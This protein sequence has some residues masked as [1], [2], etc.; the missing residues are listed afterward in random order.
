[1]LQ[2]EKRQTM[3]LKYHLNDIPPF[4]EFML[5][6]LQWLAVSVPG[7]VT[8]GRVVG[9]LHFSDPLLRLAYLQKISFAVGVVLLAQILLGHRLPLV[10]G[11]S[12]VLLITIGASTAFDFNTIYFS[13]AMGGL[14]LFV[15]AATG[16][17]THVQR[18]FTTRVIAVVLLLIAFTLMPTVLTL[19][20]ATTPVSPL[21]GLSFGLLLVMTMFVAQRFLTALWRSTLILWTMVLGSI[22][23]LLVF[24]ETIRHVPGSLGFVSGDFFGGFVVTPALSPGVLLAFIIAFIGLSV[25]DLGSMESV[26]NILKPADAEKRI[27]RGIKLTGLSNVFCGFLGVI[28][29]VNFSLSPG[30]IL[31]TGCASRFPLIP[32]GVLLVLLSFSPHIISLVGSVPSVVIG[33]VMMYVLTFQFTAGLSA[34]VEAEHGFSMESGIVVGLPLLVGT[35]VAFTPVT[36]VHS[37][38]RVLQPIAGNGFVAGM[39][40]CFILEHL[41]YR[42]GKRST[43]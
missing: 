33:A 31:S 18:L 16:L 37:F 41:V 43:I 9:E 2:S 23:W 35:V 29:P 36:I 8:I 22:A 6:G 20:S 13:M 21:Y 14:L 38:P 25:N 40:V 1:M 28:G 3:K 32:A 30:V 24:P 34:I 11:P 42:P 39:A 7:I 26:V 12:T 10:S 5:L 15:A 27:N 17:F 4:P 19:L